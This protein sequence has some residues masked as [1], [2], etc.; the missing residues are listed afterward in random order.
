MR[1]VP[2]GKLPYFRPFLNT[3]HECGS[4]SLGMNEFLSVF[5][6]TVLEIAVKPR[7]S[8]KVIVFAICN[9]TTRLGYSAKGNV[10]R[11]SHCWPV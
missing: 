6:V 4:A 11:T 3:L 1:R 10:E 2:S 5:I 7:S 9:K 8:S